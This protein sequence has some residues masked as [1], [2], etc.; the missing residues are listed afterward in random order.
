MS[1]YAHGRASLYLTRKQHELLKEKARE[2]GYVAKSSGNPK[3]SPYIYD[4]LI[5]YDDV[6]YRIKNLDRLMEFKKSQSK[7]ERNINQIARY[8]NRA[9]RE[10]E[11][12]EDL[13]K[14]YAFIEDAI[15]E[16]LSSNME[17][18]IEQNDYLDKIE[19]EIR[20]FNRKKFSEQG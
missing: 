12:D 6:I 9:L 18:L 16:Y 11:C 20:L 1:K 10:S 14:A 19:K 5:K 17:L 4:R 8:L 13:I 7:V 3:L 2:A 15:F